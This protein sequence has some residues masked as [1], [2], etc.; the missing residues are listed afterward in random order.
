VFTGGV[1][2]DVAVGRRLGVKGTV[3]ADHEVLATKIVFKGDDDN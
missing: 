2:S 3:T 1:C